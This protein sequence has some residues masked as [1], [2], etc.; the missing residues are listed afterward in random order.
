MSQ[1]QQEIYQ[2]RFPFLK[3]TTSHVLSSIFDEDLIEKLIQVETEKDNRWIILDSPSW[4]KGT[5][6]TIEMAKE[7]DIPY[8][9]VGGLSYNDMLNTIARSKGLIFI[10]E[11]ETRALGCYRGSFNGL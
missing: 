4:I 2:S 11:E 8:K 3:E 5:E 7:S 6:S 1:R 10:Q 9:L